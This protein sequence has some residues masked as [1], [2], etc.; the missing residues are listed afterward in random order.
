[1]AKKKLFTGE[2]LGE[3]SFL[4]RLTVAY[5]PIDDHIMQTARETAKA[6]AEKCEDEAG[7]SDRRQGLGVKFAVRHL[8]SI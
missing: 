7:T 8:G 3:R 1:M 5:A 2:T 4:Q 6:E